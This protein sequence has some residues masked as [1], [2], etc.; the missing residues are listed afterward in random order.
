MVVKALVDAISKAGVKQG[1]VKVARSTGTA[2]EKIVRKCQEDIDKIDAAGG[3]MPVKVKSKKDLKNPNEYVGRVMWSAP[4]AD[5]ER[6]VSL[7]IGSV[8]WDYQPWKCED[9]PKAVRK[10]LEAIRD[11]FNNLKE[12]DREAFEEEARAFLR[13]KEDSKNIAQSVIE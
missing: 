12:A 1:P 2:I 3:K 5:G 13:G 6:K 8:A 4:S 7:V 11:A 9:D 10:T